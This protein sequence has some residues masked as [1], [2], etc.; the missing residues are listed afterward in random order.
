MYGVEHLQSWENENFRSPP[1]IGAVHETT[2]II[3]GLEAGG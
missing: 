1:V 3:A 2:S